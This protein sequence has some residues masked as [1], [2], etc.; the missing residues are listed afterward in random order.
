MFP[1][2]SLNVRRRSEL[3]WPGQLP[4]TAAPH[5]AGV[6][7]CVCA[8]H[9]LRLGPWPYA[10][11]SETLTVIGLTLH[12]VTASGPNTDQSWVPDPASRRTEPSF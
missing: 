10:P 2:C 12:R 8:R 9:T 7:V 6:C 1:E 5:E 4:R 3:L 11:R